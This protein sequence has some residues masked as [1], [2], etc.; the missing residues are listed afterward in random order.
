MK[1][2]HFLLLTLFFGFGFNE[3]HPQNKDRIITKPKSKTNKV[4]S[5]ALYRDSIII[6]YAELQIL[7]SVEN[8][9]D[10]IIELKEKNYQDKLKIIKQEKLKTQRELE[11]IKREKVKLEKL[12][13]T[14]N[15]SI[16]T[17][18]VVTPNIEYVLD[19]VCKKEAGLLGKRGKCKEY[20]YFY[21]IT[22]E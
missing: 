17:L 6:S 3:T 8:T 5:A 4:N 12:V 10:E 7:D 14:L 18:Q 15:D 19:S 13:T 2:K 9:V 20:H 1:F 21:T 11:R 22:N 16:K